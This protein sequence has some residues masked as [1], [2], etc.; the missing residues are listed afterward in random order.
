VEPTQYIEANYTFYLHAKTNDGEDL[1][2]GPLF[3]RSV[4][5][6]STTEL[7]HLEGTPVELSLKCSMEGLLTITPNQAIH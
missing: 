1:V 6:N 4:F 5:Y 3:L 2:V 7:P